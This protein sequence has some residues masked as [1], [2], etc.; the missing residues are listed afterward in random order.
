MYEENNFYNSSSSNYNS[1]YSENTLNVG[2]NFAKMFLWMFF[3]TAVTFLVGYLI[4]LN[5][6]AVILTLS[7]PVLIFSSIVEI[8]IC[9]ALTK[10]ALVKLNKGAAISLFLLYSVLNGLLLGYIFLLLNISEFFFAVGISA[11]LFLAMGLFG[12]IFKN[13]ARKLYTFAYVGLG[14]LLISLLITLFITQSWLYAGISVLGVIVFSLITMVDVRKLKDMLETSNR[15]DSVAIYGAFVLYLDF[16][17]IFIYIVRL[18][19]AN[20]D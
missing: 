20:K 18:I 10:Q 16:I 3:G 19:L 4:S 5:L 2:Y 1:K 15:P 17:N 14:F 13:T 9:F 11:G 12:V 7:W 8:I 6:H